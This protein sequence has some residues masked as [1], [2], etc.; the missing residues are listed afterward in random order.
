MG[1]TGYLAGHAGQVL[2]S[3][4]QENE[5]VVAGVVVALTLAWG[6][7]RRRHVQEVTSIIDRTDP[8]PAGLND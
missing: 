6:V 8:V 4:M 3:N 7:Y 5:W 2:L 1:A